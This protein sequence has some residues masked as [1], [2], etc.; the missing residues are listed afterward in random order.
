MIVKAWKRL[1]ALRYLPMLHQDTDCKCLMGICH[2]TFWLHAQG[3]N[4]R[5]PFAVCRLCSTEPDAVELS[6]T[7]SCTGRMADMPLHCEHVVCQSDRQQWRGPTTGQQR[8]QWRLVVSNHI[9]R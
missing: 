6:S 1:E 9:T 4:V 8:P 2:V 7:P 5:Q 3:Q